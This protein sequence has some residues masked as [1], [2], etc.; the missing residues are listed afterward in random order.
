MPLHIIVGD[1]VGH[2]LEA[3]HCGQPVEHRRRIPP[4]DGNPDVV[5]TELIEQAGRPGEAADPIDQLHRVTEG[6]LVCS[7]CWVR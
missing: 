3:Q 7:Y 5:S 2:A 6:G 4:V 1:L